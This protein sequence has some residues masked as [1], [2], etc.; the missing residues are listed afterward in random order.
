M[1][2]VSSQCDCTPACTIS[3]TNAGGPGC[4]IACD[5]AAHGLPGTSLRGWLHRCWYSHH[6]GDGHSS[7]AELL[8]G[9]LPRFVV[10]GHAPSASGQYG[11]V[12]RAWEAEATSCFY[13]AGEKVQPVHVARIALTLALSSMLALLLQLKARVDLGQCHSTSPSTRAHS[14]T[15]AVSAMRRTPISHP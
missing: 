10:P 12:R 8:R 3:C 11:P 6:P 9:L 5:E 13:V 14:H 4:P 7:P 2:I 15:L 1:R